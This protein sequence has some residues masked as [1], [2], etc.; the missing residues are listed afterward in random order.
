M[1]AHDQTVDDEPVGN[2][3]V[4]TNVCLVMDWKLVTGQLLPDGYDSR[5]MTKLQ[6]QEKAWYRMRCSFCGAPPATPCHCDDPR[7]RETRARRK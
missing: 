3:E 2:V 6:Q 7:Q 4:A 1:T 5:G